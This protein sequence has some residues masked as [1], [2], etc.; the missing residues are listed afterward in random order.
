MILLFGT[1]LLAN[2]EGHIP[3]IIIH[4]NAYTSLNSH[5]EDAIGVHENNFIFEL[6][7]IYYTANR[8]KF[9]LRELLGIRRYS[10]ADGWS[11]ASNIPI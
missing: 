5:R 8:V 11:R 7:F 4:G 6:R 1:T 2:V 3:K 10:W 9:N